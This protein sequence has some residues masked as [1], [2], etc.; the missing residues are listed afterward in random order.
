M[1]SVLSNRALASAD[2]Q[3]GRIINEFK[4]RVQNIH[5][6]ILPPQYE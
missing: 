4:S 1:G 2:E 6:R 5:A 3:F